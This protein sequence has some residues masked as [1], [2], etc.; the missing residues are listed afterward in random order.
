MDSLKLSEKYRKEG[1]ECYMSSKH[2]GLAPVLKKK[3]LLQ[4]MVAYNRAK[5]AAA[6]NDQLASAL[7]N[8]ARANWETAKMCNNIKNCSKEERHYF[9][10]A[11][12]YYFKTL[13][14]GENCKSALWLNEIR[15]CQ[16][17]CLTDAWESVSLCPLQER[18]G[19]M[20]CFTRHLKDD[21]FLARCFLKI[22]TL[23]FQ[24]SVVALEATD[25]K[26]SLSLLKETYRPIEEVR[27]LANNDPFLQSEVNVLAD[28][29]ELHTASAQSMQAVATGK[30]YFYHIYK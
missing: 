18:L 13:Y 25:F 2:S 29:V 27:R 1:N 20:E 4:S 23:Q 17:S 28:D 16:N 14:R 15:M 24:H 6:N 10:E 9:G 7:K 3:R 19:L 26:T 22:A 5:N 12:Q 30:L 11:L 21:N 8:L